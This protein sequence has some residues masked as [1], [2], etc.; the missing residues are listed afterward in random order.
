M[1]LAS[2]VVVRRLCGALELGVEKRE[3]L[4]QLVDAWARTSLRPRAMREQSTLGPARKRAGAGAG[5]GAGAEGVGR[6]PSAD[7]GNDGEEERQAGGKVLHRVVSSR[8][9]SEWRSAA[10]DIRARYR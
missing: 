1:F 3:R 10:G 6:V 8:C 4:V 2:R 9:F 5:A 7:T